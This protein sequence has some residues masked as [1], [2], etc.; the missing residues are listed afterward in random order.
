MG[1][2][3]SVQWSSLFVHGWVQFTPYNGSVYLYMGLIYPYSGSVYL[4]MGSIYPYIGSV[5]LYM[6]SVYLYGGLVYSVQRVKFICRVDQFMTY[7]C[8]RYSSLYP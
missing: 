4:Y 5:Y 8:V 7:I 3:Y 2:I 1:S 6:G